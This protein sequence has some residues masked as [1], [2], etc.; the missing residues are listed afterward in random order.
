ME[1]IFLGVMV[2]GL[3][4]VF[5]VDTVQKRREFLRKVSNK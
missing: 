5:S 2:T 1:A 3:L 4:I